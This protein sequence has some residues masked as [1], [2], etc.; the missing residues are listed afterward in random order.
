[1]RVK[2]KL[3]LLH[4]E[5]SQ[6]QRLVISDVVGHHVTTKRGARNALVNLSGFYQESDRSSE[7]IRELQSINDKL[8]RVRCVLGMVP[9]KAPADV[10]ELQSP[11]CGSNPTSPCGSPRRRRSTTFS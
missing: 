10:W 1:M 8:E 11:T 6:E 4:G 7:T 3:R 5:L 2:N 9:E